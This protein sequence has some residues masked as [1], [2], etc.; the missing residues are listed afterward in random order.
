T[1]SSAIWFEPGLGPPGTS[2]GSTDRRAPN[3]L[4]RDAP[5]EAIGVPRPP[6]DDNFV[7]SETRVLRA[8]IAAAK[9]GEKGVFV[10]RT[11]LRLADAAHRVH[12]RET[13]RGAWKLLRNTLRAENAV[14]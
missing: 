14:E 6:R 8:A 1:P 11:F 2:I 10:S 7:G 13:L 5:V 12:A 3:S 9:Y 4:R